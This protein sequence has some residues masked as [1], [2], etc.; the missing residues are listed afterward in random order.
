MN[1]K[2]RVSGQHI[3]T[4]KSGEEQGGRYLEKIG[5]RILERNYRC[6]L[7]EID[8]I[9][10]KDRK[11]CFIEI[12]SRRSNRFGAPEEAVHYYKQK[13][14]LQVAQWYIKDRKIQDRSFSFDVLS[15]MWNETGDIQFRLIPDAFGL[16][17]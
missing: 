17:E 7:G 13:K 11:I 2:G 10:E 6:R 1:E 16:S 5:Y 12:K 4:G 8:V 3:K 15:I 9:A 14:I